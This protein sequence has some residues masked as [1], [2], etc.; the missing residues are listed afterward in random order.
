[1][2]I[3]IPAG[4][5]LNRRGQRPEKPVDPGCVAPGTDQTEISGHAKKE[6][7][8]GKNDPDNKFAGLIPDFYLPRNLFGILL[9]CGVFG[10]NNT[11]TGSFNGRDHL[12]EIEN[13]RNV[14]YDGTLTGKIGTGLNN[15]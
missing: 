13:A 10:C 7:G 14:F 8:Q 11:V 3:I 6:Q 4:I 1:M 5:E 12:L 15:P 9:V 2:D